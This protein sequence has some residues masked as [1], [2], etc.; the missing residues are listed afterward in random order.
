MREELALHPLSSASFADSLSRLQDG[1]IG[2]VRSL[3]GDAEQARDVVQDAFV[4]AWLAGSQIVRLTPA[5]ASSAISLPTAGNA[6]GGLASGP[7]GSIWCTEYAAGG[8]G[9]PNG[10]NAKIAHLV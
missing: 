10:A 6:V 7:D 1:L 5:G 9:G 3:V 8:P 4:D 2:F